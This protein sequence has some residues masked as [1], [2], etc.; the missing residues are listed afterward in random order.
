M[1][2]IGGSAKSLVC[3]HTTGSSGK[4]ELVYHGES[5]TG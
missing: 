1:V 4:R 2:L 3:T 5:M